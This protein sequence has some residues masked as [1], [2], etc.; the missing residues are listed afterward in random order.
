MI[1]GPPN[2]PNPNHRN[3]GPRF[4]RY[5]PGRGVSV[6]ASPAEHPRDGFFSGLSQGIHRF[7]RSRYYIDYMY[8][9]I[10]YYVYIL[11]YFLY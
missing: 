9:Y 7:S 4:R 6:R 10:L 1:I 11:Y 2:H 3:P 8:I 5:V